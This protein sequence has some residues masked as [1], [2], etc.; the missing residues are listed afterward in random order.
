ML[1][2]VLIDIQYLQKAVSSF[3]KGSKRQNHLPSGSLYPV[4]KSPPPSTKMSDSP[5]PTVE[6][7]PSPPPLTTIWKTLHQ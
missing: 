4:K 3:E 2:L 6:N 7:L 1:I 5:H